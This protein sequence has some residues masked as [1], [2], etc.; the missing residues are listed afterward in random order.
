MIPFDLPA[1]RMI[2]C[3]NFSVGLNFSNST[4]LNAKCLQR[5]RRKIP[6]DHKVTHM[7][8]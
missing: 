1:I 6:C 5:D 3:F 7:E 4:L 8:I 2:G